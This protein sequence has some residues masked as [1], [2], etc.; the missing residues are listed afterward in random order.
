MLSGNMFWAGLFLIFLLTS[1]ACAFRYGSRWEKMGMSVILAGSLATP[2][3]FLLMGHH[4]TGI[5][6][7]VL[8]VDALALVAF[9]AIAMRSDRFWPLWVTGLQLAQL[10]THM[11][12]LADPHLLPAAYEVGQGLWAFPQV[13]V[14]AFAAWQQRPKA[15]MP[16]SS[17]D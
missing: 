6:Y 1:V 14:I 9:G 4:W 17:R 15:M 8:G 10:T 16:K 3:V 7:A 5:E 2:I 12:R 13:A 11:A